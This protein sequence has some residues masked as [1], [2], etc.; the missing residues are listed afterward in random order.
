MSPI[1]EEIKKLEKKDWQLW[2]LA[3][4]ILLAFGVFILL[5]VFYSDLQ[6]LYEKEITYFD[7]NLL[8]SGF[9]ALSLLLVAY[10]LLKEYSIKGLRRDLINQKILTYNLE[11][12]F[13]EL[14][15]LFEVSTVVN[16][17]VELPVILEMICK[18]V[19]RSVE[20]NTLS[21]WL[22]DKKRDEL[23]CA[24]AY[25][26]DSKKPNIH[27]AKIDP[28]IASWVM[29]NGQPLLLEADDKISSPKKGETPTGTNLFI[30]LKVKNE[31][32]GILNVTSQKDKK[33]FDQVDLKLVSIFAENTATSLEKAEVYQELKSQTKALEKVIQDLRTTQNQLVQSEKLRALGDVAGGVAHDFNNILAVILGRTELLLKE[34]Q[35]EESKRWLRVIEQVAND[36]AQIIRR[37]QE[38]TRTGGELAPMELDVNRVILQVVDITRHRWENEAQAKGIK[39]E[40]LTQ[41]GEKL[42]PFRCDPSELSEVLMNIII[43]AIDALPQGGKIILRSWEEEGY[44]HISVEDNGTGINPEDKRR[45]FDP[46]FTT[47][48]AKGVGL[49]LSVAYGI[50]T[51]Y[52]GEITVESE[53]HKRSIFVV[54]LPLQKSLNEKAF[55]LQP[56]KLSIKEEQR[57]LKDN[58]HPNC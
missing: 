55:Y 9:I 41:L 7:Y 14:K 37:L 46:F 34:I 1:Q 10:I 48:G 27:Q 12:H 52:G 8:F 11:H 44:I 32:K 6:D 17:E 54:K 23:F 50:I 16:S 24:A 15:A 45:V 30:P 25:L 5:T 58:Y 56:E 49:G 36:G 28:E 53:P 47:K 13:Q 3:I 33:R 42:P 18:T 29:E 38:F 51:R 40:V 20:G 31:V 26:K 19:L 39:I 4:T 35:E 57:E 2:G 21:I 22:Y 43:N